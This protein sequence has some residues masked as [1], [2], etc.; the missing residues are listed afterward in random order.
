MADLSGNFAEKLGSIAGKWTAFAAFGS[1]LIYLLGYLTLRFQLRTYGVA[2]NLDLLDEKYFFAGCRFLVNLVSA[3]PNILILLL[4]L[5]AIAYVPYR[6][7]PS[8]FRDRLRHWAAG[9]TAKPVRLQVVGTVLA[10]AFIQF[11][12]RRC[13]ALDNLLLQKDLP[14]EWISSVLLSSGGMLSLYF[15]GLVAGALLTAVIFWYSLRLGSAATAAA[16]LL[17]ATFGFLAAV[18]FLL[19]PVNYGVLISTQ[20][21]PRVSELGGDERLFDGERG[22]VVWDS[23]DALTYFIYGPGDKRMLLT[24][25]RKEAKVKITAYDDIYCVLFG[26]SH[27]NIRPC[28][29]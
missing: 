18:E 9:W 20:Q 11:V 27:T 15:S 23:K 13:F 6:L 17:L 16:E 5:V 12:L 8:S 29:R 2:T 28:P 19:L 4:V 10:I 3:V 21:L 7:M 26:A 14:D 24:I 25:P 1:F 22:W